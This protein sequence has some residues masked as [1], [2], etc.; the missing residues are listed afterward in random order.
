MH[1]PGYTDEIVEFPLSRMNWVCVCDVS[2]GQ[3]F[4]DS[5][6]VTEVYEVGSCAQMHAVCGCECYM[7]SEQ[8]K[9]VGA[10]TFSE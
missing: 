8:P 7:N 9:V 1:W 6:S 4:T 5:I 10:G 2:C 3:V